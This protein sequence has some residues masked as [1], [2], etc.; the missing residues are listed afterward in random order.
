MEG[1]EATVRVETGW[2]RFSTSGALV[3]APGGTHACY[4][5]TFV[6]LSLRTVTN[7]LQQSSSSSQANSR[8]ATKKFLPIME[9]KC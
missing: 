7:S 3:R 9:P 1:R 4:G 6:G 8:S 5:G 2:Y